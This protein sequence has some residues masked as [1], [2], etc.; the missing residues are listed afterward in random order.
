V[1]ATAKWKAFIA[2]LRSKSREIALLSDVV[3]RAQIQRVEVLQRQA[4]RVANVDGSEGRVDEYD[5]EFF[6]RHRRDKQRWVSVCV[7]MM[8]DRT[9]IPP[10]EV[11]QVADRYYVKDGHHRISVAKALGHIF[12]DADV[13]VWEL[14]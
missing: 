4:I 9:T 6:P 12:V 11:I 2:R 10:V 8:K 3:A 5:C 7:A 1:Y 14:S 13:A